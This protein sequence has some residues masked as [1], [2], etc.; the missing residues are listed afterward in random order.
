VEPAAAGGAVTWGLRRR[1]GWGSLAVVERIDREVLRAVSRSFYVSLRLLPEPMRPAT[2]TGYLLARASDTL[3]DSVGVPVDERLELL[4]GF[5]DE[6]AGKGDGWRG[7][8][9][10]AFIRRQEHAGEK[11][12]LERL[13][14]C[15]A[16][17]DGLDE[18]QA[19]AVRR[20]V[21]IIVG[22]QRLDLLRFDGADREH[23]RALKN[24]EELEDYCYRVAGCVGGFWT[25]IGLL[26]LGSRFSDSAPDDLE[27]LG[28]RYGMGLQLLN[29]LRDLPEDLAQG[30]CYLPV[31]DPRDGR[32]LLACR[33]EWLGQ[34]ALWL[35][36]GRRYGSRLKMRRLRAAS[37]LPAL[38]G[39]ETLGLLDP[40]V[41][42]LPEAKMKVSRAVVRRSLWRAWWWPRVKEPVASLTSG[43]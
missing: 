4:D 7:G 9:L 28:V 39:G 43:R 13:G 6:L 42:V 16:A 22:G 21:G 18:L 26:T 41:A 30:R 2:G 40:A 25:R 38:I 14:E 27:Q 31:A 29:I 33:G 32:A 23:P 8:R 20:T 34:A 12:L 19:D 5:A 35:E 15:F 3:A 24:E 1:V 11:V 36:S 17:L 37:V 10:D